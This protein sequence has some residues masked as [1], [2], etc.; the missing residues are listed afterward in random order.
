MLTQCEK[1][2]SLYQN[3]QAGKKKI[4]QFHAE[5]AWNLKETIFSPIQRHLPRYHRSVGSPCVSGVLR[6]LFCCA[7][8]RNKL[9]I[10]IKGRL[11]CH[12]GS[13]VHNL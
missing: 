10:I 1:C 13:G 12:G 5:M 11:D 4:D 6:G 7:V 8:L 9:Y 3:V 2:D